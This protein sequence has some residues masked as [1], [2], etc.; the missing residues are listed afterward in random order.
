MPSTS[1]QVRA[2]ADHQDHPV[3]RASEPCGETRRPGWSRSPA[4]HR[5]SGARRRRQRQG[6]S[7]RMLCRSTSV[8]RRR[9]SPIFDHF[10]ARTTRCPVNHPHRRCKKQHEQFFRCGAGYLRPA[11]V[12]SSWPPRCRRPAE[13]R[14]TSATASRWSPPGRV[15]IAK[16]SV[17]AGAGLTRKA[18]KPALV[19][20]RCLSSPAPSAARSAERSQCGRTALRSATADRGPCRIQPP[21]PP[22]EASMAG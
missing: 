16:A 18:A 14:S 9:Y 3:K 17:A 1:G 15:Q 6:T 20:R 11:S 22:R 5:A 19:G 8:Q 10:S 4:A 21:Q 13:E 12:K 2:R 7:V